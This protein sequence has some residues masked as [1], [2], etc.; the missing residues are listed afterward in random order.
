MRGTKSYERKHVMNERVSVVIPCYKQ[1]HLL[2]RA[3]KSLEKQGHSDLEVIV[4][5]DGSPEP[6]ALP[7]VEYSFHVQLIR[8]ANRGLS[9]ARNTGLGYVT[10]DWIKFL[11]ADDALLPDCIALQYASMGG[12]EDSIS[13]IGFEEV[14]EETKKRTSIVPAFGDLR[15]AVL[16][17]NIGPPHIYMYPTKA[18][19]GMGGFHEGERVRGG[20]EDYDLV[21]RLSAAGYHA[22]SVHKLGAVYYRRKETMATFRE[23]MDRSRAAVWAASVGA[24]VRSGQCSSRLVLA[25]LAGWIRHA[26]I[27]PAHLAGPLEDVAWELADML[28]EAGS[29]LPKTEVSILRERLGYLNSEGAKQI[30]EALPLRLEHDSPVFRSPQEVI[31]RR[32]GFT[33]L[34]KEKGDILSF[35]TGIRS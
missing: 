26:N 32:L 19:L 23:P 30:L 1:G 3:L 2:P 27:T 8:I 17:I 31:D 16:Q 21:I 33:P 9:G 13:I 15:E 20:H 28:E 35:P 24:V 4:I 12:R 5:D 22:V 14:N 11:D 6:V 7:D 25:A 29:R 34:Q 10:G 18:I